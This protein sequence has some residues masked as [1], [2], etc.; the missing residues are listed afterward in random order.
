LDVGVTYLAL[1]ADS[2]R[3][4]NNG[5]VGYWITHVDPSLEHLRQAQRVSGDDHAW[6]GRIGLAFSY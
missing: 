1:I 4:Q 2:T 3:L 6:I 5:I